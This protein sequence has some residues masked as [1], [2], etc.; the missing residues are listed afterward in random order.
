M[1]D[2]KEDH[3]IHL[4]KPAPQTA[5]D[6]CDDFSQGI[7]ELNLSHCLSDRYGDF[8][9]DEKESYLRRFEKEVAE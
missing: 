8:P 5:S 7:K 9:K 6:V 4:T 3:I 1:I 2:I